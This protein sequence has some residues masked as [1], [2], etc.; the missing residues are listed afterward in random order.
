MEWNSTIFAEDLIFLC[1]NDFLH[2]GG[3][4]F[5]IEG[6]NLDHAHSANYSVT[7]I[8]N[9]KGNTKTTPYSGSAGR[10]FFVS[11]VHE[12]TLLYVIISLPN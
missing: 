1:G 9:Q 8:H 2:S 10:I 4:L 3:L 7:I 5:Y 11:R 12:M 6:S